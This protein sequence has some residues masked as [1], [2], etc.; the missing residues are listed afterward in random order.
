MPEVELP[1]KLI[2]VVNGIEYSY[3]LNK[4]KIL[5]SK[6]VYNQESVISIL[7]KNEI[8]EID[9]IRSIGAQHL[10]TH[11][12]I[13]GRFMHDPKAYSP[14]EYKLV[15]TNDLD[16]S[17]NIFENFI[18]LTF[19]E[20]QNIAAL[21]A[22]CKCKEEDIKVAS[23]GGLFFYRI[24]YP[25]YPEAEAMGHK[26]CKDNPGWIVEYSFSKIITTTVNAE[27]PN[28]SST[29]PELSNQAMFDAIKLKLPTV[30]LNG[31]K[32]IRIALFDTGTDNGHPYLCNN[33]LA[34]GV[35]LVDGDTYPDPGPFFVDG[36]GTKCAGLI[37]GNYKDSVLG[38]GVYCDIVSYR[39][40]YAVKDGQSTNKVIDVF[41]IIEAFI[42]AGFEDTFDV[43]NCSW[44]Y[45]SNVYKCIE[46]LLKAVWKSGNNGKG[47]AVIFA[48][49]NNGAK[50]DFP[51][52]SRYCITVSA[53]NTDGKP[54]VRS[55]DNAWG[56][57]YGNQVDIGAPVNIL[58]T[59]AVR[60]ARSSSN[61]EYE[62]KKFGKTSAAA[63]IVS[64]CVGLIL[65]LNPDLTPC[66][67]KEVLKSNA[68]RF[69]PQPKNNY[70]TGM[71][72]MQQTL[73][74]I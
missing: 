25:D 16:G 66:E 49:G 24:E 36:H 69:I 55:T 31:R 63:A 62:S 20:E 53:T 50:V 21:M 57:N 38:A 42:K 39:M 35:D 5:I 8:S 34:K 6:P 14:L 37:A 45:G 27:I 13:V 64:G 59:T 19:E 22:H 28:S 60:Y 7:S 46:M 29:I 1:E 2:N 30:D 32:K 74:R 26:I 23:G 44:G 48:A 65:T 15:F 58:R 10:I 12:D 3:T 73:S 61:I 18:V 47:V 70:G 51:A 11:I 43:I 4:D 68:T 71:I 40:F 9:E 67:I 54:I 17:D 52:N 56:S 72:N 41:T 33:V